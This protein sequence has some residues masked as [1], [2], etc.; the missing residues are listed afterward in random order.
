MQGS[1]RMDMADEIHF[2]A[3]AGKNFQSVKSG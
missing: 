3:L 2:M 1:L